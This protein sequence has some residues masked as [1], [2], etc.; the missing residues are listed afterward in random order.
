MEFVNFIG[1]VLTH[2]GGQ[3]IGG[4]T[5]AY[6]LWR[7]IF[8]DLVAA[9]DA[10]TNQSTADAKTERALRKELEKESAKKIATLEAKVDQL[11]SERRELLDRF[12]TQK[13]NHDTELY[14]LRMEFTRYKAERDIE[15]KQLHIEVN[16]LTSLLERRVTEG[17]FEDRQ[18]LHTNEQRRTDS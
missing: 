5:I 18:N 8:K 10:R 14:A 9:Y 6:G 16:R 2:P 11:L 3:A 4:L 1:R 15:L 12:N 7:F 13:I 17:Q